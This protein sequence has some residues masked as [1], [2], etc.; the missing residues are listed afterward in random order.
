MADPIEIIKDAINTELAGH[1]QT[2]IT[3]FVSQEQGT[4]VGESDSN[5]TWTVEDNANNIYTYQPKQ[6]EMVPG[7]RKKNGTYVDQYER[8]AAPITVEIDEEKVPA[9]VDA[10]I[11]QGIGM[12]VANLQ[13][14]I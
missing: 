2:A 7:Y 8:Q 10:A 13:S 9:G 1:I 4:F 6:K 12:L 14:R 11:Q 5:I 3:P